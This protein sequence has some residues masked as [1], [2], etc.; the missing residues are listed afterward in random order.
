MKLSPL[1]IG[2]T[3]GAALGALVI[4]AWFLG[5]TAAPRRAAAVAVVAP[6][7]APVSVSTNL[8]TFFVR[9]VVKELK[10]DGKTVVVEH[11][12]I[13]NYMAKMTMPFKVKDTNQITGLGTNDTIHFRFNVAEYESWID[14]VTK[15]G[16]AASP[17]ADPSRKSFRL[18]REVE[19]L[20]PGDA[21]PDYLFTNQLGQAFHTAQF[22]GQ[23]LAITFIFTRCPV[24]DFCPRMSLRFAEATK[25]L[26]ALSNAPTNFHLLSLSFDVEYDTPLVLRNYANGVK[27]QHGAD[28]SKWSFA[29]GALIDIDDLTERFGMTFA[30]EPGTVPFNHNLRTVVIDAAGKVQKIY[31]GNEWKADDFV[32]ELVK[33]ANAKP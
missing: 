33:A 17:L 4:V 13:P 3:A 15:T 14:Q 20:K 30:R 26:K 21:L 32:T 1:V 2:I 18:V 12:E 29:T 27:A 10:P 5:L 11:E 7:V 6:P 31:I 24:P 22:K 28:L 16:K 23:A 9:G 25:Q 19:P 8:Q